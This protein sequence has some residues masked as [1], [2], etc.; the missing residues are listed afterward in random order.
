MS[1]IAGIWRPGGFGRSPVAVVEPAETLKRMLLA[2]ADSDTEG[3]AVWL[4][5]AGCALGQLQ[6]A[7]DPA[8][9]PIANEDG[10]LWLVAAGEL[11]NVAP[12]RAEL[13]KRHTFRTESDLEL[14]LHL[15]EEVGADGLDLVD[16]QFSCALWG[17]GQ[18]LILHRDPLGQMD[19]YYGRD[20]AGSLLFASAVDSLAPEVEWIDAVPPGARWTAARPARLA[21]AA[22]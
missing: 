20:A 17:P 11:E 9:K 3:Q 1:G 8:A 13:A 10:T 22:H 12:L 19:L 18:E 14:L 6:L 2:M 4:S 15:V 21:V 16:G 5:P 7:G